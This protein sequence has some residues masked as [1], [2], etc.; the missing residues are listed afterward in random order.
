MLKSELIRPRIQIRNDQ[1]KPRM[2]AADYHWLGI[3]KELIELFKSQ[4]NQS[5][6]TLEN[7]LKAYEGD[8]LDYQIMRGLTAVLT[9][10]ATFDN[11]PPI[12]PAE[13]REKLFAQGPINSHSNSRDQIIKEIAGEYKLTPPQVESAFFAD[14]AEEQI[15]QKVGEPITPRELI[16]R[17]NMEVARGLLYWAKE[18]HIHVEDGYREVFKFIKLFGLMHTIAP[19]T[20]GYDITLHGPISPFVSSTIRYGIQFAKFLPALLLCDTWH[21]NASVRPPGQ[22]KFLHYAMDDQTTLISHFK[23]SAGFASLLESNFA[24]EFE[25]KYN[26]ANRIW[27]LGYEDELIILGDTVMIPDFSFT[28]RKNGRRAL[29]EIVGFWHPNYLQRKLKKVQ[30]ANRSDLILLVYENANVSEGAFEAASAGDV[31]T[32]KSKPILKDVI[33]A[34][35]ACAM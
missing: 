16:D 10:R 22:Q 21:M 34:I 23:S 9:T 2:L 11:Q 29:L 13:L 28:H 27:E 1:L 3:A 18:M 32:F 7:A 19:S 24:A 17:Y 30:Q 35:E 33:S 20:T 26:R 4:L 6:G 25:S 14:L 31:L 15:L 5:R 8:S 12:P